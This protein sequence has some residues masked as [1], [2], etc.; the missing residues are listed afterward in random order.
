MGAKY[1]NLAWQLL[2]P[3]SSL[4]H[5][6]CTWVP[7][8]AP[9]CIV[10]AVLPILLFTTPPQVELLIDVRKA[11]AQVSLGPNSSF[12]AGRSECFNVGLKL[13]RQ[14]RMGIPCT[15]GPPSAP[16]YETFDQQD[17]KHDS[18][19]RVQL[20]CMPFQPVYF[21]EENVSSTPCTSELRAAEPPP[22]YPVAEKRRGVHHDWLFF[23]EASEARW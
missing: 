4:S 16:P 22:S 2:L 7:D 17:S 11:P 14:T 9:C 10:Q 13:R 6:P 23:G 18:G 8:G 15:S 3:P 20:P 21:H 5:L 1:Q 19:V 12:A